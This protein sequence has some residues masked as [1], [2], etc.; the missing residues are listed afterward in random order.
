MRF[1]R[2]VLFTKDAQPFLISGSGT[3][4]WDQV[5][6]NLVE[7]GENALVLNTGYFGDSFAEW[8][9]YTHT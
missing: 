9:V 1:F 3:L 4:G 8:Y 7:P 5:A 6:A 2:E